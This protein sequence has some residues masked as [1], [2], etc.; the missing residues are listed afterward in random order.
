MLQAVREWMMGSE[1]TG[2]RLEKHRWIAELVP[3]RTFADI[4]GLW[5]TSNET[6][7]IAMRHGAH[8]A[9]MVDIQ[10]PHSKWWKAFHERCEALGISGYRSVVGDICNDRIADDI[11][12]FDI[13]HCSGI[14]YHLPSPFHMIRNLISIT[15]ERFI[16]TSMVVPDRIENRFG[17]L[18]LYRGQC[19]S[20]PTLSGSRRDILIEHFDQAGIKAGGLN[21]PS[22]P[23][24]T[25]RG[26]F[27]Y[28]PWWWLFSAETVVGMCE[29]FRVDIEK[30]WGSSYG[31]FSVLARVDSTS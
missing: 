11:G 14:I 13:T 1:K 5:G 28:G 10:P 19:L 9:T 24:V 15:R 27:H 29:I 18:E 22:N 6:V 3:N 23:P 20:V 12:C 7:S 25:P 16:L 21:V 4:G 26:R 8:E 30:T 17:T 31:S 2:L